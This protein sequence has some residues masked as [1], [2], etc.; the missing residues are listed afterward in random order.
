MKRINRDNLLFNIAPFL[1]LEDIYR[2]SC[3]CKTMKQMISY[4]NYIRTSHDNLYVARE[5]SFFI[6]HFIPGKGF[7]QTA[8]YLETEKLQRITSLGKNAVLDTRTFTLDKIKPTDL[9]ESTFDETSWEPMERVGST[10]VPL[11]EYS[12]EE[13]I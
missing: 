10:P 5:Y 12:S 9:F 7:K 6:L 3:T 4:K 1:N 2:L 13:E 11:Y 8:Y